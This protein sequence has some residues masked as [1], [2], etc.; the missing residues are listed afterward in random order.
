MSR[1]GLRGTERNGT[2]TEADDL[3]TP[4]RLEEGLEAAAHQAANGPAVNFHV[5]D[6]G[7]PLDLPGRRG[8]DETDFDS[9]GRLLPGHARQ[10]RWGSRESISMAFVIR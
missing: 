8:A 3:V 2:S 10:R 5:A 4:Q 6:A 1:F 7:R 9:L